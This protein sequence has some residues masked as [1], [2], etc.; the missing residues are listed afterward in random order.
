MGV[1]LS[2]RIRCVPK[3]DIAERM[4]LCASLDEALAGEEEFPLQQVYL[5]PHLWSYFAQR[6]AATPQF[7]P[8]R[9]WSALFYRAW[10]FFSI[11]VGLHA[12]IKLL[13]TVLQS[14]SLTRS[15]YRHV[16]PNAILKNI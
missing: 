1:I 9:S 14:P 5:T 8:Q 12:A 4:V 16:L 10:W 15:F 3:Y 11:D 2:A 7:Q 13:T 6:R